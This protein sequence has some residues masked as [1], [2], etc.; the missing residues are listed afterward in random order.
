[1]MVGA[2]NYST[3]V[4]QGWGSDFSPSSAVSPLDDLSEFRRT[5]AAALPAC[6]ARSY[7]AEARLSNAESQ[8]G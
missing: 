5:Q 4:P 8:L 1:M 2:A 6:T 7:S 3:V